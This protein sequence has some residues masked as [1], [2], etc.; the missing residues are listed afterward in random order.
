MNSG[1]FTQLSLQI[2]LTHPALLEG[3]EVWLQLGLISD[4]KVRDFC[5]QNLTCKL[6][7]VPLS[8][9]ISPARPNPR[10]RMPAIPTSNFD[11][12]QTPAPQV[13]SSPQR[14]KTDW[15]T[16]TLQSLMA[17]LSVLW[18]LL[19]GVFMVVVSSG[20][21]AASQWR[22]FPPAGQYGILLAYTLIFAAVAYGLKHRPQLHLTARMLQLTTLLIIP[23]N[24]WMMDQLDLFR[25]G[26]GWL[27]AAIAALTLTGIL[28]VLLRLSRG[29]LPLPLVRIVNLNSM[30]LSWLHWGWERPGW[31]WLAT[32]TGV[33]A[34][35]IALV[36]EDR[37]DTPSVSADKSSQPP[38]Q[39]WLHP[40]R[41]TVMGGLLLLLFRAM[42]VVQI[43]LVQMSLAIAL[44]GWLVAWLSRR[45]AQPGPWFW[46]GIVLL[47][48]GRLL[49]VP[50]PGQALAITGLALVL[51]GRRLWQTGQVMDL[52]CVVGIGLQAL[53]PLVDMIPVGVRQQVVAV[54]AQGARTNVGMPEA[55]WGVGLFPYCLF[56]LWLGA[57][58]GQQQSARLT[59]IAEGLALGLGVVLTMLSCLN[60]LTRWLNLTFSAIT[61]VRLESRRL[62]VAKGLLYLTQVTGLAAIFAS[63]HW[64]F[65]ALSLTSWAS[66]LLVAMVGE[67]LVSGWLPDSRWQQSA[68]DLGMG[69]S[70]TSYILWASQNS[71]WG[72]LWAI[73]PIMLT[74]LAQ[75]HSLH[76]PSLTSALSITTL[77][78]LQPLTFAWVGPRLAGLGLSTL[79]MVFN[80]RT[81]KSSAAGA[82][83][84]GFGLTFIYSTLWQVWPG[85]V[86]LGWFLNWLAVTA[87]LL[88]LLHRFLQQ[89]RLGR[90]YIKAI[91]G[92][93]WLINSCNLFFISFYLALIYSNWTGPDLSPVSLFWATSLATVA[94]AYHHWWCP[95]VL[96]RYEIAAGLELLTASVLMGRGSSVTELAIANLTLGGLSLG[97][98]NL[99]VQQTNRPYRT[100]DQVIPLFYGIWGWLLGHT[101]FS[102]MTGL[103]TLAVSVIGIGIGRRRPPMKRITFLAMAGLSWGAYELLVY[104]LLQAVGGR[105]GDGWLLLATLA[106]AIALSDLVLGRWLAPYLKLAESELQ[107]IAH[108]HWAGGSSLVLL[109]FWSELSNFGEVLRVGVTVGLALYALIQGRWQANWVYVGIGEAIAALWCGLYLIFPT[110]LLLQWSGVIACLLGAGLY[111]TPWSTW[112]WPQKPWRRSALVLPLISIVLTMTSIRVPGLLIA[113]AFYAWLAI[114]EQ[115]PRV[116]YLSVLLADWAIWRLLGTFQLQGQL[117]AACLIGGSLLYVAQLDPKF[118]PTS[119]RNQRHLLRTFAIGL[120]CLSVLTESDAQLLGGFVAAGFFLV[121]LGIGLTSRVRAFAYG[122]TLF[123]VLKVVRQIWLFV[124]DQSFLLW[125][126]GIVMGLLFIWVA[127]TFEARRSQ[128]M[129]LL[130][131]WVE[132]LQTWA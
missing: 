12:P 2:Q 131:Y 96:S 6:L 44:Y 112:G 73:T 34:T 132:E 65:P 17:E 124:A 79:L 30:G 121:L 119:A 77:A 78:A 99:R 57:R 7:E 52:I 70:V 106:T 74:L 27:V 49:A 15:L 103:Y 108:L 120:I 127:A 53:W 76:Q 68:G 55:L 113:G 100:S 40:S 89:Q 85:P 4:A 10:S 35:C 54:A 88:W 20:V 116:S 18:L 87:L 16:Q 102:A 42:V 56:I 95:S 69:L 107:R 109:A 24:F 67:W 22:Y 117:A 91:A 45:P 62:Q 51:F 122:G 118:K 3:L 114:Q 13:A 75:R 58:L 19:L 43:P 71:I 47:G 111:G 104:Q 1:N 9:K 110:P 32:I 61:L 80:T 92:W 83:T 23:V 129:A 33:V 39:D 36:Y 48:I 130:H 94:I 97:L 115:R 60:P 28:L 29:D 98:S 123:F 50:L 84:V 14:Q 38:L 37:L 66:I 81:L 82:L 72:G 46:L 41:I 105:I 31:P 101:S 63:L 11:Q 59:Q 21:L 8:Q 93:A 64:C 86:S 90:L 26:T 25:S 125:A 126:I 5:Q 128:M